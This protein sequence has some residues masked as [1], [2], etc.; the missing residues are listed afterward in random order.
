[1]KREI[2]KE[3]NIRNLLESSTTK[4]IHSYMLEDYELFPTENISD[5]GDK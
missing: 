1:M 5:Y 4:F 2:S 3:N